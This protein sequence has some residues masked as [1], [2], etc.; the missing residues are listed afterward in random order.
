MPLVTCDRCSYLSRVPDILRS[1]RLSDHVRITVEQKYAFCKQCSQVVNAEY[2]PTL[3]E[4]NAALTEFVEANDPAG[5]KFLEEQIAWLKTRLS[6]ARCLECGS[7][8]IIFATVDEETDTA[9]LE[10]PDC[11]GIL[12]IRARGFELNRLWIFYTPEGQKIATYEV[13]PSRG[14]VNRD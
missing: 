11:G 2:I 10:H 3:T 1:Y 6:P 8:Q 12:F 5:I 7:S 14:L 9:I 4:L 13:F